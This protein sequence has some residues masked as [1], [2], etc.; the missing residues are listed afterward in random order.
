[1][2]ICEYNK[3]TGCAA[4]LNV[5]PQKCISMENDK[6]D[7]MH[8]VV[9]ENK[10][11]KCGK[12]KKVCPNNTN[13]RYHYPSHCYAS[14]ITDEEKRKVCA[15]GGMATIMSEYVIKYKH[16]V[17]FGTKYNEHMEPI[18]TYA[19]TLEQLE[20]FKGSKYVQSYISAKV[21]RQVKQ[22]LLDGRL[23]LY[24]GTPCQIAGLLCFL[25][26]DYDNLITV[27][28]ICH[29]VCPSE[30]LKSE[31]EY[32]CYKNNIKNEDVRDIRF[33]GNDDNNY[34]FTIWDRFKKR[35]TNNFALTIW[36]LVR[37]GGGYNALL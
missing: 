23:V 24:V 21:F 5:C 30:Y 35:K 29:G 32:V 16:G 25:Q 28:L 9:N 31:L 3:C 13:L 33:R 6:W 1:M 17:V 14:W 36:K 19:E 20:Y 10:C 2:E 12:C 11:V 4:C 8:P 15:S 34:H 26:K 37:G 22:F 18:T 7:E 27:D